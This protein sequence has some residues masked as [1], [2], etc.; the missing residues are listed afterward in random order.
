MPDYHAYAVDVPKPGAVVAEATRVQGEF[1]RDVIAANRDNFLVFSPD[2]TNSNR[3]NAV[4]E[5]TDRRSMA[6]IL[7]EDDHVAVDGRVM[8]ILSE[9]QCQGWLEG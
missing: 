2:E 4:F 6:E 1:L 5:V 9:H 8:E 3:W 7:P